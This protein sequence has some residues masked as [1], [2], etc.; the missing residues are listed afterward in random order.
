[1]I[2][3]DLNVDACNANDRPYR[4]LQEFM[5]SLEVPCFSMMNVIDPSELGPTTDAGSAL[6]HIWTNA[7]TG[8]TSIHSVYY[9]L[10][11]FVAADLVPRPIT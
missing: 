1:M 11:E 3:G 6:D 2:M 4:Q 8:A 7:V 10:H 9:S 5:L